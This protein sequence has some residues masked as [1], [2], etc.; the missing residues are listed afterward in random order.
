[1]LRA[2]VCFADV[3]WSQ[4]ANNP[5]VSPLI[6]TSSCAGR[7]SG[8]ADS[9]NHSR[10]KWGLE[11]RSRNFQQTNRHYQPGAIGEGDPEALWPGRIPFVG[12]QLQVQKI[13]M[14]APRN[15]VVGRLELVGWQ[16]RHERPWSRMFAKPRNVRN[17]DPAH[18]RS[19]PSGE[20]FSSIRPCRSA[21]RVRCF[22]GGGQFQRSLPGPA[23]ALL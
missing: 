10:P 17:R 2:R 20:E 23:F 8:Q 21:P 7:P 6:R 19:E 3:L 14:R 4:P 15:A 12:T 13:V 18:S 1:M 9:L 22:N 5:F 11:R 16:K